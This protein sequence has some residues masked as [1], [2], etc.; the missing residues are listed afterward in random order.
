MA[1]IIAI[2]LGAKII[3]KHITLDR[4]STGPDHKASM[5]I[6][7]LFAHFVETIRKTEIAL[8]KKSKYRHLQKLKIET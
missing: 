4:K 3:E 2:S 7:E 6:D 1:S 5:E 8:G